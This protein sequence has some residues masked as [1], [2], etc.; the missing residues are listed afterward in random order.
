MFE[1]KQIESH[2]SSAKAGISATLINKYVD[3]AG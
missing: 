3:S 1:L 2:R